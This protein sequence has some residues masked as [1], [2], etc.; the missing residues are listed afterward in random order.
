V[1]FFIAAL[2][3]QGLLI[4]SSELLR[5]GVIKCRLN[6]W[7]A[8]CNLAKNLLYFNLPFENRMTKQ[9]EL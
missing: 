7:N 4:D 2:R 1:Q 6:S 8:C 3:S 9:K 5:V